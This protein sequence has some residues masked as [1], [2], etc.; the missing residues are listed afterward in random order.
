[1]AAVDIQLNEH[2]KENL[3]SVFRVGVVAGERYTTEGMAG[4]NG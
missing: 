2:D 4:L 3:D 1:M